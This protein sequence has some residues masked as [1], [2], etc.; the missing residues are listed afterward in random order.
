MYVLYTDRQFL[1][2]LNENSYTYVLKHRKAPCQLKKVI[3]TLFTSFFCHLL[4]FNVMEKSLFLN[5]RIQS[6]FSCCHI[7]KMAL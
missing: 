5:F 7:L 1:N 2:E 4:S 3:R 6:C